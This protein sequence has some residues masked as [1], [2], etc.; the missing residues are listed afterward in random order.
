MSE[1]KPIRIL[2]AE[3]LPTDA[4]MARREILKEKIDFDYRLVD[5]EPEFRKEL[6]DFS[7]DIVISD[8]SMPAFD[9]MTAL[10]IARKYSPFIPFIVL[11]G[12]MNEETAVACMKLCDKRTDQ[13][14]T[15]CSKRSH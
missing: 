4:E 9:G 2:F 1:N 7:P 11:T 13:K 8:Y 12:S 5:T 10:K 15:I 6:N 14:V 3:D